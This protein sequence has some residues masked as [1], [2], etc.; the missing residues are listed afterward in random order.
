MAGKKPQRLA[1]SGNEVENNM[2]MKAHVHIATVTT[3]RNMRGGTATHQSPVAT[4]PNRQNVPSVNTHRVTTWKNTD[5]SIN[6]DIPAIPGNFE[7]VPASSEHDEFVDELDMLNPP[8]N[9]VQSSRRSRSP[10]ASEVASSQFDPNVAEAKPERRV[11]GLFDIGRNIIRNLVSKPP[12]A[13][14]THIPESNR[15][16]NAL[17]G[18]A[19]AQSELQFVL[20]ALQKAEEKSRALEEQVQTLQASEQR[21][22]EEIQRLKEMHSKQSEYVD[23]ANQ[24]IHSLMEK[25]SEAV[26]NYEARVAALVVERGNYSSQL[27]QQLRNPVDSRAPATGPSKGAADDSASDPFDNKL[28]QVSEAAVKSGVESLN[29]SVD[30]FAM[31]VLDEAEDLANQNSHSSVPSPV[32]EQQHEMKPKLLMATLA[33]HCQTEEKRGFLLDASLHHGLVVELDRLF[34]SGE[35]VPRG[36]DIRNIFGV[37]LRELTKREPWTV[38]QRWRALTAGTA[39]NLVHSSTKMWKT[40]II[41]YSQSIVALFAWAYRQPLQTFEPL[42][43]KIQTRLQTLYTEASQLSV[44]ARR[45][46]L[47]VRMAVTVAPIGPKGVEDYLSYNNDAVTSVWPDMKVV[48]GDEVIALYKFGLKKSNEKGQMAR[49]IKPEVVTT[50]LL[51]EVAKSSRSDFLLDNA[52]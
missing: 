20:E 48:E 9:Q 17:E 45:D 22:Q 30:N 21:A 8:P 16:Q 49:L 44:M 31:A 18:E 13:E 47:C 15:L 42:L 40:S 14:D 51:R 27:K 23:R 10:A 26:K 11:P 12:E 1:A 19:Q 25:H 52:Y 28:D 6:R 50:A 32:H 37:F 5:V 2:V 43:P 4:Q 35:A 24:K 36:I 33:E 46:V 39:G 3:R 7:G 38:V 34:F 41:E 29:D